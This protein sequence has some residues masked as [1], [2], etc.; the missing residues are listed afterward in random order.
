MQNLFNINIIGMGF[1][2]LPLAL[3]LAKK[4]FDVKGIDNNKRIIF[5][6][7][8]KVPNFKEPGLKKL[9]EYTINDKKIKFFNNLKDAVDNNKK[10][11]FII[12]IGTPISKYNKQ[13]STK[14]IT[15]LLHNLIPYIKE[16][17][18]VLMRSTIKVGLTDNIIIPLLSKKLKRINV[19]FC[20][21]RTLEGDA[22][23]ELR[24]NSQII[25]GNNKKTINIAKKLFSYLTPKIKTVSSIKIAEMTK[26]IDNSYRDLNFSFSNEIALMCEKANIDSYEAINAANYGY[27]RN[28]VKL[29]GPVG[30]SCLEKDPYIL[31][32]SFKNLYFSKSI[33][34]QGRKNNE[35]IIN[36]V[37]DK[38]S[39]FLKKI[40]NKN[41]VKVT[42]LGLAFKG[43]PE[44]DDVR[45]SI[46]L[47]IIDLFKENFDI[48]V[49]IYDPIVDVNQIKKYGKPHKNI[50]NAIKNSNL[51][52][53]CNNHK[54]FHNINVNT[55]N[56]YMAKNSLIFDFWNV[57]KIKN[58]NLK[59]IDLKIFGVID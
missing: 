6:L 49:D 5:N 48:D 45:G 32:K 8:K 55:L 20:P 11:I 26:L 31:N 16:D 35:K 40:G 7:K 53:V 22:L 39:N 15:N 2:G 41:K 29:P 4:K 12:T 10:N 24:K 17:D 14:A 44:T 13:L 58:E 28:S 57:L 3:S 34:L 43:F 1:V 37:F 36:Y 9:L 23:N 25:S 46:S 56:K 33:I 52:I 19:G 47:K 27:I 50:N 30:G 42:I 18:V 51:L 21:E 38:F 54:K 59:N